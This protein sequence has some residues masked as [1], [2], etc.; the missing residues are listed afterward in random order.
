MIQK[1]WHPLSFEQHPIAQGVSYP[2]PIALEKALQQLR[3]CPP[4][5][6]DQDIEHLKKKIHQA[7][8]GQAFLLQGGDCSESF[9]DCT[10]EKIFNKLDLLLRMST[11]LTKGLDKPIIN[12]GRIA[13]QYAK[14]RSQTEET[15]HGITLPA[16]R[17]DLINGHAFTAT[18]R[19]P[20][21]RSK[22]QLSF[23]LL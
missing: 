12:I 3:Q 14:P 17:G 23:V 6:C 13:G 16:Y 11:I 1:S 8:K 21:P 10:Q 7:S 20:T 15:L 5:V 22:A 4:L 19:T 9:A 2:D 18:S